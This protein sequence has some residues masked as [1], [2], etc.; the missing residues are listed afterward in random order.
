VPEYVLRHPDLPD[1][2]IVV[3]VPDGQDV[4]Q[5]PLLN[6][7]W[8]VDETTTPADLAAADEP[9]PE[10]DE[11]TGEPDLNDPNEPAQ[12]ETPKE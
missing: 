7:G 12:P 11:P 10:P 3:D 4:E 9:A 8:E 6:S 1:Q 2:P 5:H